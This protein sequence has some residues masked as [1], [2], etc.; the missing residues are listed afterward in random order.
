MDRLRIQRLVEQMG[1]HGVDCVALMPGAN[2]SYLAGVSFRLSERPTLA[3]FAPHAAPVAVVPSFDVERF[4]AGSR[5]GEWQLFPWSDTAGPAPALAAA[6]RALGLAGKALGIEEGVMRVAELRLLE[7]AAPNAHLVRAD[8]LL[9]NLRIRKDASELA[10]MRRAVGIVEGALA[11]LLAEVGV[12]MSEQTVARTLMTELTRRGAEAM[13][14]EPIVLSGPNSS[15]PHGAPGD[16]TLSA[17]DLLLLD[18]GVM[19][20]GY[21]CD[22]TRTVAIGAIDPE[23]RGVYEV[24]KRANEAGRAA[25]QPGRE[26]QQIDRA[27]RQVI[28]A[29]GY[30]QYFK[31]RTGHGLGLDVHEP[32]YVQEGNTLVLEPG[33]TL[34][35]EPGINLPGRGG[36]RIEDDLVITS[37]GGESLTTFDREL[38]IL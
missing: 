33:M 23:L 3:F 29:A 2:L 30:G 10:N 31:R 4:T 1:T 13:A 35:V 36:V 17:G 37:S 18:F 22:I 7:A 20:E 27:A 6:A 9:A 19:I 16:R 38:R 8:A 12:G 32:P 14:F 26:V 21:A 5:E 15:I 25:A 24:V 34:T 11:A 28:V